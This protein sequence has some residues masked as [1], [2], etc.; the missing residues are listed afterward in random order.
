MALT[1][2]LRTEV[3]RFYHFTGEAMADSDIRIVD[4]LFN[5]EGLDVYDSDEYVL[6]ENTGTTDVT[7]TNWTLQDTRVHVHSPYRYQFTPFMLRA[8]RQVKVWTGQGQN[9]D[10]NLFWGRD[11]AVWNNT[12][13]SAV[14][15]NATGQEV[16]RFTYGAAMSPVASHLSVI[17][18][19]IAEGI[20]LG[21]E[22][23]TLSEIA[24]CLRSKRADIVLL[25]EVCRYWHRADQVFALAQLAGYPYKHSTWTS[26]NPLFARAQ[27]CVA[28]L[29]RFPLRYVERIQHSVYLDGKG[30]A[31]L[32]VTADINN[33]VHHIFSTRFNAYDA[34]E[35]ARSHATL[36]DI[37]AAIPPEEAVIIGG[38]FNVGH[39]R[40]DNEDLMTRLDV[41]PPYA[42]F[43]VR[44]GLRHVLG[45]F[46]WEYPSPDDHL[47]M[48][49]AYSIVTAERLPPANPNPS[50]H[51][52]VFA[53]LSWLDGLDGVP[54]DDASV[55]REISN[56]AIYVIFG[57]AKVLIPDMGTLQRLYGGSSNVKFVPDNS[58]AN[59]P[60]I[61]CNGTILRE[62]SSP[63][64]WLIE[65]GKRRHITTPE[66]LVR[67][68]GW[69]VVRIVPD[70]AT[71][72]FPTGDPDTWIAPRSWAE[73]PSESIG[74]NPDKDVIKFTVEPN[75]PGVDANAA[76]FILKLGTGIT[77]RK[78]LVLI[79]DDGQWTL[80][81]ENARTQDSNGL[82]RYQ[83][84]NGRL[85]FRK[86]KSPGGMW[87][88][89]TLSN[90]DQLPAG[91]K[92]TFV[93]EK[94]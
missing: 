53:E 74:N 33:R 1:V 86:M 9:N 92:V 51:P 66:V 94:D 65:D 38:D 2:L 75:A 7:L 73:Y 41:L 24:R 56:P 82:Y 48:R 19:N 61:P 87:D 67:H 18:W 44:T 23:A 59:I 20:G 4:V 43:V 22:M 62:E 6:I 32:H 29:S 11:W 13:D 28:V 37:I 31:T 42:D 12:G 34:A 50:D 55:L 40:Y 3:D 90:L 15:C 30:Y 14:L 78:E 84:P 52:W 88:V 63:V 39:A 47:L 76:E 81:V 70:Q 60:T 16:S 8:G 80:F 72:G 5:P 25:N 68:G 77:W 27:K 49:G 45:G 83:L 71:T 57:G 93:W 85:R 26:T 79:A 69:D 58:L 10:E 91:A 36:R 21:D 64:V 54:L 35:I 17:A 89:H 46:G